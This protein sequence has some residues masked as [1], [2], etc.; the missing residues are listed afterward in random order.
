MGLK[1]IILISKN[2]ATRKNGSL[3]RNSHDLDESEA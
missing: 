3:E 2:R 1:R